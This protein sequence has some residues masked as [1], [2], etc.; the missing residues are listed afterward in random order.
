VLGVSFFL[1]PYFSSTAAIEVQKNQSDLGGGSLGALAS[2]LTGEDDVKTELQTEVSVLES[3]DLGIETIERTNFEAHQK[4]WGHGKAATR[5]RFAVGSSS[6][7]AR[8]PAEGIRIPF[9]NHAAS[10]HASDPN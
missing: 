8:G 4:V 2:T 1:R 10:G 9:E 6:P 7:R 5:A 3:D